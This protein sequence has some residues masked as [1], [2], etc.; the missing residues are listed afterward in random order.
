MP[1]L[2]VAMEDTR[3]VCVLGPRQC[4]KTTLVCQFDPDRPFLDL[5]DAEYHRLAATDPA[6]FVAGLPD[7]VTIDEVQ[8]VPALLP[9]IRVAVDRTPRPGRFLLTG[10]ADLLLSKHATESLAGRME[11]LRLHPLT[12]A[13]KHHRQGRFLAALLDCDFRPRL[14][15]N[16][17]PD[18][19]SMPEILEAGGF[20]E[21]IRRPAH[22]AREWHRQYIQG[23]LDRDVHDM[24]EVRKPAALSRLVRLLAER[25]ATLFNASN[26][27]SDLGIRRETIEHYLAVLE[28][29]FLV[30][31]LPP[32]HTN[33][34]SRL[35][36][37]PK[38]HFVDSGMAMALAGLTADDW[39]PQRDRMGRFLESFVIE[40][41]I[42][43]GA[44][45]DTDLEFWH[46]RD[47]D[48]V[49]VDLVITKGSKV[50]GIE[51]KSSMSVT[52]RDGQGLARLSDRCGTNFVAGVVLYAGRS[53]LP[54][55]DGRIH[56]VPLTE[57]WQ[58]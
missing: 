23:V 5:D 39:L 35:V 30:R 14:E 46:Y 9:A 29:L 32:W 38:L 10:S 6:G 28:R 47:K 45:T 53:V 2:K 4:G 34:A 52:P 43:Q 49:E 36:R 20:P 22:R 55:R 54:L 15:P 7:A 11:T 18:I 48:R 44:W 17:E 51:V 19:D 57:L 27:A 24:G 21:P 12:E 50:W 37:S 42:T 1:T 58:R 31:R 33:Q 13:E 40:Q 8:R 16:R 56:A 25:T 3:I 41:I 26:L